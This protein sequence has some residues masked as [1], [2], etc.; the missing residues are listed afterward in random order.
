ME[1]AK[2]IVTDE[3]VEIIVLTKSPYGQTEV[4]IRTTDGQLMIV[5]KNQLLFPEDEA[6]I[7]E[8]LEILNEYNPARNQS[9]FRVMK[10]LLERE[11]PFK[12]ALV[13]R[14]KNPN[15]QLTIDFHAS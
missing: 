12:Q 1:L 9:Y 10:E 15:E 5:S 11:V 14:K 2:Y 7:R 4:E 3:L 8:M 6:L 13:E